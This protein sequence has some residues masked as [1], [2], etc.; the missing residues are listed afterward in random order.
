MRT[1]VAL[2]REKA[3]VVPQ[4][5]SAGLQLCRSARSRTCVSTSPAGFGNDHRNI[6][7]HSSV[8][9]KTVLRPGVTVA[10]LR[11]TQSPSLAADHAEVNRWSDYLPDPTFSSFRRKVQGPLRWH[12]VIVLSVAVNGHHQVLPGLSSP[13]SAWYVGAYPV[14][15]HPWSFPS[16]TIGARL[17]TGDAAAKVKTTSSVPASTSNVTMLY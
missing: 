4:F 8:K 1:P 10:L 15:S 13:L 12:L 17:A 3:L 7:D 5:R 6:D 14:E 11:P 2:S 9:W 16:L